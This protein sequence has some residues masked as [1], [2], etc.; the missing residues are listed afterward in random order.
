M[1]GCKKNSWL[2]TPT[3][4][5][6]TTTITMTRCSTVIQVRLLRKRCTEGKKTYLTELYILFHLLL[7][8]LEILTQLSPFT[9]FFIEGLS[10]IFPPPP[11][12]GFAATI[13]IC[14]ILVSSPTFSNQLEVLLFFHLLRQ[15]ICILSGGGW[16]SFIGGLVR[17]LVHHSWHFCIRSQGVAVCS[18]RTLQCCQWLCMTQLTTY[19]G[20]QT[21]LKC[22]VVHS[23]TSTVF[24]VCLCVCAGGGHDL[25]DGVKTTIE[26]RL[27]QHVVTPCQDRETIRQCI[28]QY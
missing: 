28:L 12:L 13:Q 7:E 26:C 22:I 11:S 4:P 1:R 24:L 9:F 23:S 8:L 5:P 19:R 3:P 10:P 20:R 6:T 16:G 2:S 18:S 14:D 21:I 15:V 17:S 25:M 27:N